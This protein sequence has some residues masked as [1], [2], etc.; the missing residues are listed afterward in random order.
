MLNVKQFTFNPFGESTFVVYDEAS[1]EAAVIDPGM[2]SAAE[3]SLLD[4][5]IERN[6]LKITQVINTHLH[7]DHCFGANYVR[8]RY[9]VGLAGHSADAFLGERVAAQTRTFGVIPSEGEPDAVAIDVALDEGDT[10]SIGNDSLK[11]LHVPGHSP[12][13]IALY[14]ADGGFVITGDALF[15]GSIGRT[16][17]PGGSM[18]QLVD[19]IRTKLF[20]LPDDTLVLPGHGPATTIGDEKK[21]NPYMR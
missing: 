5:F 13:S 6:K 16:D 9:G 10:I 17:L 2:V 12:G 19:S 3:R 11:V 20:T 1:R 21:Y 18:E 8:R 4:G 14:C 7:V 15:Q